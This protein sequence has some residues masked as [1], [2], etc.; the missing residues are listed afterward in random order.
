VIA[1]I[2]DYDDIFVPELACGAGFIPESSQQIRIAVC[3]Q[4]LDGYGAAYYRIKGTEYLA[5]TAPSEFG[6][7]FL[8][9]NPFCHQAGNINERSETAIISIGSA[10]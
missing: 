9:S 1:K 4:D 10:A 3:Q 5:E 7:Q 2:V 8:S 6:L